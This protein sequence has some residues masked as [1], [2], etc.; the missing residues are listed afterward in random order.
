MGGGRS[1]PWRDPAPSVPPMKREL[2]A[3]PDRSHSSVTPPGPNDPPI[4]LPCAQPA[5]VE[6]PDHDPAYAPEPGSDAAHRQEG[7]HDGVERDVALRGSRH[8]GPVVVHPD[9]DR[10]PA[11]LFLSGQDHSYADRAVPVRPA[12][13]RQR[14][15]WRRHALPAAASMPLGTVVE[16]DRVH[17]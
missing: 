15:G 11:T 6:T 5:K 1:T 14:R 9:A 2:R 16:E 10:G 12:G 7:D 17:R 4:V 13:R 3:R 8:D